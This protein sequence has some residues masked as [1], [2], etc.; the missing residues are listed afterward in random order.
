MNDQLNA[1]GTAAMSNDMED[2]LTRH[3][4]A[5]MADGIVEI[6]LGSFWLLWGAIVVVPAMFPGAMTAQ[7]RLVLILV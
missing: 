6:V 1:N 7:L 3:N 2:A 5:W 4:R